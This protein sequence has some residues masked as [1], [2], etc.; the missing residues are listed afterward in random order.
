MILI[1]IL[2]SQADLR[3]LVYPKFI[4][5]FTAETNQV[6]SMDLKISHSHIFDI[7][8]SAIPRC[9]IDFKVEIRIDGT[10]L[11]LE[12]VGPKNN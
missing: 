9:I 11:P 2:H 12:T 7:G 8:F 1:T 3:F 4:F 10:K 6:L 5:I